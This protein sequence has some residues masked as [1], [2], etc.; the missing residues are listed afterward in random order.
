[1]AS[2]AIGETFVAANVSEY[3]TDNL[4]IWSH[5]AR[6]SGGGFYYP[7]FVESTKVFCLNCLLATFDR[8]HKPY[9]QIKANSHSL[10]TAVDSCVSAEIA[11]FLSRSFYRSAADNADRCI[12]LNE[13]FM[14][15]LDFI[16]SQS[17]LRRDRGH[18]AGTERVFRFFKVR[19]GGQFEAAREV[20]RALAV[21]VR[22]L[23]VGFVGKF[24]V[25]YN[26]FAKHV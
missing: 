11:K 24:S 1:M 21:P 14:K 10:W 20:V 22:V 23:V 19:H 16:I 18:V 4:A 2:F 13:P 15:W 7:A 3:W 9:V 25:I 5:F 12:S 17:N 26:S 6:T 8:L